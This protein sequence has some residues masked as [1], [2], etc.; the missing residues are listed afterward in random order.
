[1]EPV[2]VSA[3]IELIFLELGEGTA[4]ALD[5]DFGWDRVSVV[6]PVLSPILWAGWEGE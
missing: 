3:G 5:L 2:L 1:M 4:R 6:P